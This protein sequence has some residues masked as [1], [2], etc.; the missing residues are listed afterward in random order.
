MAEKSTNPRRLVVGGLMLA[1]GLLFIGG[2]GFDRA[3]N[4]VNIFPLWVPILGF[5]LITGGLYLWVLNK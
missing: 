3:G 4:S 5:F 2:W 1:G